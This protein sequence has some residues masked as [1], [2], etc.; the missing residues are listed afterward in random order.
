MEQIRT[1]FGDVDL[2]YDW[3]E[4][5]RKE[6]DR[7]IGHAIRDVAE[8]GGLHPSTV[9]DER[10]NSIMELNLEEAARYIERHGL[11]KPRSMRMLMAHGDSWGDA[12]GTDFVYH[13]VNE[14]GSDSVKRVQD[15]INEHDGRYSSLFVQACNPAGVEIHTAKSFLVYP[16]ATNNS[17]EIMWASM[18][19]GN[20][21]LEVKTPSGY[22]GPKPITDPLE[23]LL[24]K[25]SPSP[26]PILSF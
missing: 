21:I 3:R 13:S 23:Q 16:T 17:K 24:A 14:D 26:K 2:S 12:D 18:G 15:W 10:V 19:I 9:I 5:Y 4:F 11:P 22:S 7:V 20:K 1:R 6:V 8:K 25:Y